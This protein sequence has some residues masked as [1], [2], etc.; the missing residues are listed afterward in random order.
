MKKANW[1]WMPHAGHFIM[2]K[3]CQFVLNTY[4]GKYIVSTVGELWPDSQVRKITAECRKILIEG[5]GDAWDYDYMQKIGFADL[6]CDRKY[7]T[8]VFKAK[9]AE[10]CCPW[11][12][13]NG[14]DLDFQGYNDPKD[15]YLGHLKMCVK[16][17]KK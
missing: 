15:A 11:R 3:D 2:G 1:V 7:E 8:M 4:I 9:K 12:M 6:G 16:W 10:G 13:A 14:H 17:S 5:R